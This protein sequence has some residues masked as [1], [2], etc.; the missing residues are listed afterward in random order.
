[1]IFRSVI[2]SSHHQPVDQF[3]NPIKLKVMSEFFSTHC[4][5]LFARAILQVA[6][7]PGGCLM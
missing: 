4:A 6:T 3:A 1:M 2:K 5:S 7:V